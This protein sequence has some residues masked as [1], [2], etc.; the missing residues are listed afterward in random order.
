MS[1]RTIFLLSKLGLKLEWHVNWI[2]DSKMVVF[3]PLF[4]TCQRT[5]TMQRVSDWFEE[6]KNFRAGKGEP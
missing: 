5:V 3:I 2:Q 4:P 6:K 1:K